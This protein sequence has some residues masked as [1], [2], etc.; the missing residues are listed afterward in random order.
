MS[1]IELKFDFKYQIMSEDFINCDKSFK[2]I[3]VGD[4]GVGK[5]CLTQKALR[6][7][8]DESNKTTIGYE[9]STLNIKIEDK[10]IK[11]QIWD[12]CGQEIYRSLISNFYHNSALAIIVYSIT[13]K[14]SFENIDSWYNELKNFSEPNID[15]I[16]L[17]N[18]IDLESQRQVSREEGE[19]FKKKFNLKKFVECS[20]K[21]GFNV[22]N[23]F[24]EAAKILYDKYF[25]NSFEEEF[26]D[27][28]FGSENTRSILNNSSI[29]FSESTLSIREINRR[30]CC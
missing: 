8:F 9:Y 17:G 1:S 25:L 16:L 10:I 20:A 2:I 23:I 19:N 18:K 24:I 30:S 15:I 26:S 11:L 21:N 22:P 29:S 12:T 5:S 13:N 4:S 6:N 14:T 7:K 28:N 3:I 27:I